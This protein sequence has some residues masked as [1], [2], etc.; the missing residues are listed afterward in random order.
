M[1][2]NLPESPTRELLATTDWSR[3]PL[4]PRDAWPQALRIAVGI[5][6]NSRFPMFV[7]W[8]RELINLYNDAYVPTLGKRHPA[9]FG[10]PARQSWDDIWDV[11]GPQAEAVMTRGEA[12]WNER[13]LLVMER[14]G[15]TENTWFTW[16]YSPI[17]DD[18]GGIGGLFCAVTEETGRVEAERERDRLLQQVGEERARLAEAFEQSPAFLAVLDGPGHVFEFAND[19]YYALIGRREIIGK[20]LREALPEVRGQG[21]YEVLDR[22]YETGEPFVGNGMRLM[23]QREGGGALAETFVD[24]VYRPLRGADGTVAGI[25][26]HGVDV[27]ERM[28]T[29]A[30]D[31]FLLL[32]EET[33][34]SLTDPE[35][36][37]AAGARLLAEYLEADRCNYADVEADENTFT[38]AGDY[39]RAVP[40]VSGRY[41]FSDFGQDMLRAMRDGRPHVVDDIETHRPPLG[42]L[43]PYRQ[44]QV[45]AYVCVPLRKGGRLVA[46]MAVNQTTPRDW[47]R[48]QVELVLHVANRCWESIERA[49][50]ERT[51]RVSEG[52][53]RQ[54][55]D[56]MPQIV[57]T[58]KPDGEVDYFNRQWY[59]YTGL[60]EGS[61]GFESWKH[62][63]TAEGLE[64]VMQVWPDALRTGTP[65][66]IEYPLRRHDG[67]YRWHL[68][69][70]LP[71][72]DA[73][74][75][76]VRWFGTNTDI[77]DRKQ[78]ED[79]LA[80]ALEAEQ[81]ARSDAERASRMKDEFLATLSHELRTPLNAILGWAQII[82][83]KAELPNELRRGVDTI[84]RNARAQAQIIDDLLDMSAIIS[85]K[86]RLSVHRV[87]FAALV[88][89]AIE[90]VRPTA[91]A[92]QIA[93]L[94]PA[95]PGGGLDVTGDA[96][97]LQQ[98]SWNLL[99]NAIKFT[100]E[101]GTVTIALRRIDGH[102]ELAVSDT[103]EG[104]APEFLPHVFD[105]FRQADATTTRR[106]GGLGLGL[107]IVKQLV[108]LH[109]GEVRA[110][111]AG[112]GRG[113]TF[114]VKLPLRTVTLVPETRPAGV[115][116]RERTASFEEHCAQLDGLAVLVVDDEPDSRE[117]VKRLL[118]EC[119]A[120]VT[121]ADSARAALGLMAERVFDVLVS[122]IGMP[123]ADGYELMRSV[124]ALEGAR[125]RIP[126]LALTAYARP[127]DRDRA[128]AAGFQMH[129][130]KPVE[131]A[132]LVAIVATLGARE[133]QGQNG[134]PLARE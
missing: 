76:V 113:S 91:E 99:S 35:E 54:L 5:C 61:V 124:R 107:A 73:A 78:M 23:V 115:H 43:T 30:R 109:G 101:G 106:Y 96:S 21:F 50:V 26:A 118:E 132:A 47:T 97:R 100:P 72:K 114:V 94:P 134:F 13:V 129:L 82:R 19:R 120:R 55:A 28:Q 66:E 92:R 112:A 83:M 79:A 3:T 116:G 6:L 89:S 86:V 126:A 69:R 51:L 31:R 105:R 130:A 11:V 59:E 49:R 37:T 104:I 9:A 60:V 122:D 7:W 38:I 125:A 52:R 84:E 103:G 46:V 12:T 2:A 45:R 18:R 40:H 20:P 41:R 71:I 34:R 65:Y 8:G 14:H 119:R 64:R 93:L 131:P 95:I 88:Q 111:S 63:H 121:T 117:L 68:G 16:S 127:D 58:A 133:K 98:V 22:V 108:E 80:Q 67:V 56:A 57:F 4:G 27:T 44:M 15:Y 17:P 102:V 53:F 1:P 42:D 24:F 128:I 75:R 36:I 110:E 25:L 70:A 85:G 32:L 29:E 62:V 77:H 39:S 123:G 87:D 33:M 81:A 90:T 48:A 10:R 74:G